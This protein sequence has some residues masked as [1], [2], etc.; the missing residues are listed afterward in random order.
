MRFLLCTQ[1]HNSFECFEV[2]PGDPQQHCEV[3]NSCIGS[4]TE[5]F[6]HPN[7]TGYGSLAMGHD[8]AE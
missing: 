1:V 6:E 3:E 2:R 7:S 4:L 5:R 8:T